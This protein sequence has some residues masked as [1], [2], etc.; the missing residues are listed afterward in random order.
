MD[1]VEHECLE[2]E[3]GS[4]FSQLDALLFIAVPSMETVRESR[5]LQEKKLRDSMARNGDA[6]ALVGLMT[7]EEVLDYVELFERYTEHMLR[8]L[9]ELA[10]VHICRDPDFRYTVERVSDPHRSKAIQRIP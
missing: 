5:W 6:E 3:Y 1:A 9:P 2:T 7:R 4:L 8:T 10:D